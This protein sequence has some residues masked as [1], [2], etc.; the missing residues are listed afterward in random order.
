M[1]KDISTDSVLHLFYIT[2][3]RTKIS[4]YCTIVKNTR[5]DYYESIVYIVPFI[6]YYR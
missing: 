2:F 3:S 4:T 5:Y 6:L 1:Y